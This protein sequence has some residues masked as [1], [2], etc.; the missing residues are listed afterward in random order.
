MR[1]LH[2][3]LALSLTISSAVWAAPPSVFMEELTWTD[4]RDATQAG[5]VTV[6]IPVGGTEQ[7]GPHMALGKHNARVRALA[8]RIAASLGDV[9]VAPVVAYVPEGGIAPPTGHMR[10]AGTLSIPDDVFRGTL[11]AAARSLRQHGFV[12]IVLIGD[13]GGYQAQ[14]KA[15]ALRLNRDWASTPARAHYIAEYYQAF[16]IDYPQALRAKGL[17]DAQIGTHAGAADTS[18]MMAIDP[19]LVKQERL[20]DNPRAGSGNGIIGDPR[21]ASVPLG[22]VGVELIV[23]KTVAAIR[24][25]RG[26]PR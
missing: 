23:A 22:Q 9:L 7:N 13:H 1:L 5:K 12:H 8:G 20:A 2:A 19:S 26:V 24:S 15:V 16:A 21:S 11:D 17:S 3:F 10:F 25:A 14:L 4:V 6:L 18:L